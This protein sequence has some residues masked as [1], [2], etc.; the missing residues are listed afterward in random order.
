MGTENFLLSQWHLAFNLACF[1]PKEEGV[2][3]GF[4]CVCVCVYIAFFILSTGN[5]SFSA[6][7]T[8]I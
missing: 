1:H 8:L 6:T 4:L 7:A 5:V 2:H 3:K